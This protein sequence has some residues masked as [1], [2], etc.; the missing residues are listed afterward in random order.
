MSTEPR[1]VGR[2]DQEDA[3]RW[4]MAASR[5]GAVEMNP[6]AYSARETE[7]IVIGYHTLLREFERRYPF[8][9]VGSQIDVSTGICIDPGDLEMGD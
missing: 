1:V 9:S 7:E 4:L 2:L 8:I 5:Y 3:T 6:S